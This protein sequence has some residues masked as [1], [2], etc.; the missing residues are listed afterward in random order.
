MPARSR[1]FPHPLSARARL[2]FVGSLLQLFK[3]RPVL[4]MLVL[5]SISKPQSLPARSLRCPAPEPCRFFTRFVQTVYHNINRLSLD[6]CAF[7]PF[8]S[9]LLHFPFCVSWEHGV[10]K[11]KT[12]H[13]CAAGLQIFIISIWS[14]LLRQ[15]AI[16][17]PGKLT[18][19]YI[20]ISIRHLRLRQRSPACP[21]AARRPPRGTGW[22]TARNR[23]RG[24]AAAP[25][26]GPPRRSCRPQAAGCGRPSGWWTGGAR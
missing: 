8:F 13:A 12:A 18:L 21:A 22:C 5:W 24:G 3:Q 14:I 9:L 11:S 26:A 25:H 7:L 1:F 20:R 23:R 10:F 6:F 19:N 15:A 17:T 16:L 2:H 4:K